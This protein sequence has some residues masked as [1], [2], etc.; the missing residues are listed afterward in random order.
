VSD[1]ATPTHTDVLIDAAT[2]AQAPVW[3]RVLVMAF[4][5]FTNDLYAAFLAP[6]LPLVVTKFSLSLALAGLLG[7]AFNTSGALVQPFFGVAADRISRPI[8]TVIG[9]L[10]TCIGMGLLGFA[11]SYEAML[12]LLLAAGIGT[13]GF[14]PQ[15]FALAGALSGD[16]RGAG[17][18]VFVAGGELGYALGPVYVAAVVSILGLGGTIL[19]AT[20]GIVACLI[21]WRA[22]RAWPVVR[23]QPPSGL[24]S[25]FRQHGRALALLWI[26]VVI[27]SII[28]LAHIIFLPLLLRGRGQS[29]IVGGAAVLLFGG[30]GALGGLTGGVLSDRI[31]RR[32][33]MSLSFLAGVPLLFLFGR[34]ESVWGLIPLALGGYTFYLAAPVNVVMAQEMLPRRASL[35][36]SLVT[37]MAWGTAGLSLI[38]VGAIA[39]RIGLTATLL[40]TLGL[41][42][43][44]LPA[45]WALP[46][47]PP[48]VHIGIAAS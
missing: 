10:V 30:I 48:Q 4:A 41:S 40:G 14:H 38:L 27:R 36:S 44:A 8:F 45:I 29:L 3:P 6:L 42:V 25:D 43:I 12:V 21:I 19:A 17:L 47:R 24:G 26:I 20:P 22:A 2:R 16:R 5:H 13:A 35:A 23:A 46:K 9:P 15:S 39:D 7:T 28:T 31:G 37:G 32:A 1:G 34:I 33:V 18:S 11:P